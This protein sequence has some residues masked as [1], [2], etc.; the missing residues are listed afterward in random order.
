MLSLLHENTKP[1][2]Y[3]LWCS[4]S[5]KVVIWRPVTLKH[6][7]YGLCL[8]TVSYT[9]ALRHTHVTQIL[10]NSSVNANKNKVVSKLQIVLSKASIC[11]ATYPSLLGDVVCLAASTSQIECLCFQKIWVSISYPELDEKSAFL[12]ELTARVNKPEMRIL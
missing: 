5:N 4:Q 7:T 1:Q 10:M 9:Y 6:T 11:Q 12:Y 8:P 3:Y 2:I